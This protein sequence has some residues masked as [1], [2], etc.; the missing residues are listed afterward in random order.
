MIKTIALT[1]NTLLLNRF[2][3]SKKHKMNEEAELQAKIAALAGRINIQKQSSTPAPSPVY[4]PGFRPSQNRWTPYTQ[5]NQTYPRGGGY[6]KP[7][8]PGHRNK[9]LV[10][11]SGTATPIKSEDSA[12]TGTPNTPGWVSKRDRGNMQ[13]INTSVYDQKMQQKQLDMEETAKERQ[14]QRNEKEKSKVIR[15]VHAA[16]GNAAP[17]AP[18]EI[19]INDMRFR[20]AADGSKLIRIFDGSN[21]DAQTTPKEAKIAGVTFH[22]SKNGNLYRAGLV[23]KSLSR[24]KTSKCTKLCSKFTTTGTLDS[25]HSQA[26]PRMTGLHE[27]KPL[28]NSVGRP[29]GQALTLTTGI[30]PL[31]PRCR[32]THDINKIAIC[33]QFLRHGNCAAGEECNLSH[34]LTPN[35]VPLCIH[36]IRGNCTN[37]NCRYAH[38]RPSSSAHVCRPFATL[39]YCEKGAECDDRHVNECPDY[40]NTGTCRDANCRLPHVDSVANKRRADAAKAA[41]KKGSPDPN[42]SDMSSDE[43]DYQ[44]IDSDD[45]DSDD[46]DEDEV[47]IGS[48]EQ[49]HELSQQQDFVAFS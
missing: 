10:V 7:G 43:E 13:L 30:C 46:L 22:R 34:D 25:N 1:C 9:T 21:K 37:E 17:D 47:M 35:R 5:P 16:T 32:F 2:Q 38:V 49:S 29:L 28:L 6:H 45:V 41:G 39:G 8:F 36:F 31:G 3:P 26:G 14:R 19:V 18:R 48:G 12:V 11:N 15:H 24:A 4:S 42:E 44:E 40:A 27:T 33:Q 23:K 20:V